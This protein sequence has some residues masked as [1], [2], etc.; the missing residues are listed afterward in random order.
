MKLR[1]RPGSDKKEIVASA[2]SSN[3]KGKSDKNPE[4]IKRSDKAKRDSGRCSCQRSRISHQT[5]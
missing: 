2:G 5:H 1:K 3:S 4:K